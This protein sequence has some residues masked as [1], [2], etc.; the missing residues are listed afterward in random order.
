MTASAGSHRRLAVLG[1][2]AVATLALIGL[3]RVS[4]DA[5][6]DSFVPANDPTLAATNR[7][8]ESFGG[9]PIVVLLESDEPGALLSKVNIGALLRLEGNLAKL[10]NVATVYGPTTVLNQIAG[11]AQ[12]FLAELVSGFALPPATRT[13]PSG[14]KT[15]L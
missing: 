14:S 9:D 2:I 3:T 7:V 10:D 12:D 1:A 4:I 13:R 5:G 11:Q 15:S 6:V 8:A